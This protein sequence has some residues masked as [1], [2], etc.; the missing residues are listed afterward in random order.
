MRYSQ[1]EKLEIIRLVEASSLSV[2]Q[3]LAELGVPRSTFYRWYW[4]YQEHGPDGLLDQKTG[5]KQF[6]NKM[7]WPGKS[8]LSVKIDPPG[9]IITV[10]KG[11]RRDVVER[12]MEPP[13]I[14]EHFDEIEDGCDSDLPGGKALTMKPFAL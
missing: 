5:P 4:Q 1:A 12:R 8:G 13:A 14:V 9:L 11:Q 7:I 3:T 10:L 2:K 6:W